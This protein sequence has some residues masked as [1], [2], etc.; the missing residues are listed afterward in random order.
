MFV[1][2]KVITLVV[3]AAVAADRR[4]ELRPVIY[5]PEPVTAAPTVAA[6]TT[7]TTSTTTTTQTP[8]LKTAS[9]PEDLHIKAEAAQTPSKGTDSTDR[10]AW[11]VL[12]KYLTPDIWGPALWIL[13]AGLMTIAV[14]VTLHLYCRKLGFTCQKTPKSSKAD[15]QNR[16]AEDYIEMEPILADEESIYRPKTRSTLAGRLENPR[17]ER[18]EGRGP[19]SRNPPPQALALETALHHIQAAHRALSGMLVEVELHPAPKNQ[20]PA[21]TA[22]AL[23]E[24][25]S[26]ANES[27]EGIYE[28]VNG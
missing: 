12:G 5:G 13:M 17:R 16:A 18:V 21:N 15:R 10:T 19:V 28:E 7:A 8:D 9:A 3:V 6:P 1:D 2:L 20:E 24:G 14:M 4:D 23:M 27:A 26:L 22:P 25:I 11:E